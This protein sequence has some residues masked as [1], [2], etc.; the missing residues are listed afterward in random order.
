MQI[1]YRTSRRATDIIAA[2]GRTE[3]LKF[4]PRNKLLAI[5]AYAKN[6]IAIFGINIDELHGGTRGISLTDAFEIHSE[7]LKEPHGVDFLDEETIVVTNRSG[8]VIFF[9]LPLGEVGNDSFELTPLGVIRSGDGT[10]LDGPGSASIFRIDPNLYEALICSNY[11]DSVTRH[12][13]DLS[14]G[15][16][17]KS[18]EILLK[19]W[20]AVPDGVSVSKDRHWIAVSNQKM[21]GV[22]LYE[23]A[24]SLNALS[25]PDGILRVFSPH[26][27]R[28]TSDGRFI[29][30]S[31][32]GAPY[33]HIYAKNGL[34]W[35]GVLNPIR[36]L[37][38]MNDEDFLRG[39]YNAHEGG[40]KGI[41][42]D[43]DMNILA[44][45]CQCRPLVF[46]NLKSILEETSVRSPD[47]RREY[48]ENYSDEQSTSE[49]RYEL[50]IQTRLNREIEE[51]AE[52]I[53][54]LKSSRSWRITAPLRGVSSALRN[55]RVR[56][57]NHE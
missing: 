8:D 22:F 49:L 47:S 16:S 9:K 32:G 34:S 23:Y 41:D 1:D 27:V 28:F 26:G 50:D 36:S 7:H 10:L 21:R 55:F 40:P 43:N 24:S 15:C 46:F 31:D 56:R 17:V 52:G 33:V 14:A 3:D 11:R 18:N 39:R 37:R 51:I 2:M 53:N 20:L 6:K 35:R 25:D 38:V 12:L 48:Q 42:I 45:T 57:Q 30:V 4:S 29:V 44:I 5:A 13:V 19:K 54:V